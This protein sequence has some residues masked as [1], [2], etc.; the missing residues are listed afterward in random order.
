MDSL[1]LN[2]A[3]HFKRHYLR[4]DDDDDDDDSCRFH[5]IIRLSENPDDPDG[6]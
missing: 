4:L 3:S 6:Y 2:G 1:G 5:L